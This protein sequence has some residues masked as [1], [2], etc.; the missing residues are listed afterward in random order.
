MAVRKQPTVASSTASGSAPPA[1]EAPT[2]IAKAA[3]TAGAMSVMAWKR[4]AGSPTTPPASLLSADVAAIV[5]PPGLWSKVQSK[6]P[7]ESSEGPAECQLPQQRL[8]R[9]DGLPTGSGT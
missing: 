9:G 5:C 3:P 7:M 4:S 6:G 2:M 1:K 8:E